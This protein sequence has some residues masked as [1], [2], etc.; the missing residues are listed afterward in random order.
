M[1]APATALYCNNGR[2]QVVPGPGA[3]TSHSHDSNRRVPLI[4]TIPAMCRLILLSGTQQRQDGA[5]KACLVLSWYLVP[6]VGTQ[7][8]LFRRPSFLP[9][10]ATTGSTT[11]QRC[12]RFVF[13]L[14][15]SEEEG[16][17][18]VSTPWRM[19]SHQHNLAGTSTPQQQVSRRLAMTHRTQM[20]SLDT[21]QA[22]CTPEACR[23]L[24]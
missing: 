13:T 23:L 5:E 1:C 20:Q 8:P 19:L 6:V 12:T 21:S 24:S 2:S 18:S 17:T 4:C 10:A 3:H 22:D 9:C 15:I 11:I 7:D 14:P 16:K